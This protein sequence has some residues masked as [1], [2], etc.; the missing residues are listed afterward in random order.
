MTAL[1]P[2]GRVMFALIFIFT[3]PNHFK[4]DMIQHAAAAGT[5]LA[6]ILVPVSGILALVGGLSVALGFHARWGAVALILF[7][8]P[9]TLVMHRFW[10]LDDPQQAQM[11]LINFMK[12]TALIGGAALIAYHGAGAF[13]F[14]SRAHREPLV[15]HHG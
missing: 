3:A 2:I 14:D 9:V 1:A 11:Q 6:N 4:Q 10:G 12:N 7:L 13:S 8:V 5:P 15:L